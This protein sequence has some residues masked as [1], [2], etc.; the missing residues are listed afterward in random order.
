MFFVEMSGPMKEKDLTPGTV[1]PVLGTLLFFLPE[2]YRE[3][4]CC[5]RP[6]A[7]KVISYLLLY[8]SVFS[9][10]VHC[11]QSFQYHP[12]SPKKSTHNLIRWPKQRATEQHSVK[13]TQSQRTKRKR[14]MTR[15]SEFF[16]PRANRWLTL[17]KRQPCDPFSY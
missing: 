15:K 11:N 8:S 9:S 16:R 1:F 10:F 6:L 7:Q 17:F 14:R 5:V 2:R 13:K 4:L 12:T 3:K